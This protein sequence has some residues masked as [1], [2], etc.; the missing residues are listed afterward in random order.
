MLHKF[1]FLAL[2]H[3]VR[4]ICL[5]PTQEETKVEVAS[6][7]DVAVIVLCNDGGTKRRH[8]VED[9]VQEDFPNVQTGD[10]G[11]TDDFSTQVA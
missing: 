10:V 4:L 7:V 1:H 8:L 3:N 6:V 2:S 9:V 11:N 5:V